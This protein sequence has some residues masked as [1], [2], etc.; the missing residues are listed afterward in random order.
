MTAVSC[1]LRDP[2]RDKNRGPARPSLPEPLEA[3]ATTRAMAALLR[4]VEDAI[5]QHS[6]LSTLGRAPVQR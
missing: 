5:D 1:S 4:H 2:T 6:L 3:P